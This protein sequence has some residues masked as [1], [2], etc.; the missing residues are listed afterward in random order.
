MEELRAQGVRVLAPAIWKLITLDG[1][2]EIV[3]SEYAENARAAG[4]DLIAWSMERAGPLATGG[5]W[6]YQSVT[7]AINNDGDMLKV[8]DVLAQDVGVIAIFSDWPATTTFYANCM[9]IK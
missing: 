6:Y 3:P 8:I 4:L 7:D 9:N 2:G 5:G 1:R